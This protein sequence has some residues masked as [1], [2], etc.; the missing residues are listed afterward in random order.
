MKVSGLNKHSFSKHL[1][2]IYHM[3]V[4]KLC[5]RVNQINLV[6]AVLELESSEDD[7]SGFM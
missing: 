3:S 4:L 2:S 5:A 1:M 6:P 7:A